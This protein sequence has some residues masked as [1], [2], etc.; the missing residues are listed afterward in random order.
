MRLK[1][2]F[3]NVVD[4]ALEEIKNKYEN[5][6]KVT[7]FDKSEITETSVNKGLNQSLY[8]KFVDREIRFIVEN[9]VNNYNIIEYSF[10]RHLDIYLQNETL[11]KNRSEITKELIIETFNDEIEKVIS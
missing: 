5:N 8:F 7:D 9:N 6:A 2:F 3:V 1:K 10:N 4:P 11:S